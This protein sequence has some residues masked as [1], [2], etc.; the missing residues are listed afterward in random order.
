LA[1]AQGVPGCV[2]EVREDADMA[3]RSTPRD[4][5]PAASATVVRRPLAVAATV[6]VAAL[7]LVGLGGCGGSDD[8]PATTGPRTQAVERLRDYGLTE[9]QAT[10]IADE[11]GAE[12][13]VEAADVNA[14][15]E[16]QAYRDAAEGCIDDA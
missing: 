10:C 9:D 8:D 6:I 12:T 11:L 13:V 1:T 15:A 5:T 4:A 14:L 3:P 16:G 2:G 7:A